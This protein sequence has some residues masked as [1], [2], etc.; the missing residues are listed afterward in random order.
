ML[1]YGWDWSWEEGTWAGFVDKESIRKGVGVVWVGPTKG[2][3]FKLD[4]SSSFF[5]GGWVSEPK[6]TPF[7][8]TNKG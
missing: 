4:F 8:L 1:G 2:R 5:W 3:S 6:D 7:P